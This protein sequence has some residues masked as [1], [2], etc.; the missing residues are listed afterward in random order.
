LPSR[1]STIVRSRDGSEYRGPPSANGS[2]AGFR[3]RDGHISKGRREVFRLRIALDKKYPLIIEECAA[4]MQAVMPWNKVHCQPT[5]KNYVE[6]H[7][8]SKSTP[9]AAAS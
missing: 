3:T 1:V 5:P 4:S 8:Y 6:V 2:P 9:T 7:A